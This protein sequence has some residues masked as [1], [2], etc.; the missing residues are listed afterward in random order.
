MKSIVPVLALVALAACAPVEDAANGTGTRPTLADDVLQTL[1]DACVAGEFAACDQLWTLSDVGTEFERTAASCGGRITA[2]DDAAFGDCA[3]RFGD[4]SPTSTG[5]P[6]ASTGDTSTQPSVS[7]PTT[8]PT[9]STIPDVSRLIDPPADSWIVILASLAE[10]TE[11]SRDRALAEAAR[12]EE[13]GIPAAVLS[14][15]RFPSLSPGFWVVYVDEQFPDEAS[16]SARCD[17]LFAA[18]RVADCYHRN[19]GEEVGA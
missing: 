19:V 9:A 12:L 4:S 7:A 6:T 17:E 11:G 1:E 16:A 13:S 10:S 14:T 3:A 18:G 15:S 2:S 5:T 8:A